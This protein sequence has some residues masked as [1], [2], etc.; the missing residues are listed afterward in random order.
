MEVLPAICYYVINVLSHLI[1]SLRSH[2]LRIQLYTQY[3]TGLQ[4]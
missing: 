1:Q 4:P 3:D 2:A